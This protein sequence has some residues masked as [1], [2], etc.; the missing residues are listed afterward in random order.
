MQRAARGSRSAGT[1]PGIL[2]GVLEATVR[3]LQ[4]KTPAPGFLAGSY[5]KVVRRHGQLAHT[6]SLRQ[7]PAQP[8]A[9]TRQQPQPAKT[10]TIGDFHA[11]R[12]S[13]GCNGLSLRLQGRTSGPPGRGPSPR[14]DRELETQSAGE[15]CVR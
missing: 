12:P 5:P 1:R 9:A 10:R 11:A 8:K 6:V 3:D 14:I 2:T 15:E 4:V 7:R 13:T